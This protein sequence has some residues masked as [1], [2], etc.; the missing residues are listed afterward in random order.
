MHIYAQNMD[1]DSFR[2]THNYANLIIQQI[3]SV[4]VSSG[5]AKHK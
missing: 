1:M 3:M 4:G 5:Q 2:Q